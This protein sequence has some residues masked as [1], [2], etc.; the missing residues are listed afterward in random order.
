MIQKI[1]ERLNKKWLSISI[2]PFPLPFFS[3][4]FISILFSALSL[5][6]TTL[7]L[8]AKNKEINCLSLA[9]KD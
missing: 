2:I 7:R 1:R 6:D 8:S 4:E 5:R 3:F 9:E